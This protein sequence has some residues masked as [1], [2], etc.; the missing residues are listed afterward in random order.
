[1]KIEVSNGEIMDKLTIL[2]IKLEEIKDDAKLQ[3][4]QKE[5]DTLAPIVH[6]IYDTLGEELK[7]ELQALHKDLGDINKTLWNIEDICRL[8]EANE[9]FDAA[10]IEVTRSVYITNDERA[11]VKK[12]INKL[13]GSTLVEEKS[14]EEY[15]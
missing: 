14:Y 4:V 3:N 9:N 5:Y 12:S 13:T 7:P 8:H 6:S 11:E 1:M 10:F 15:K 2:A